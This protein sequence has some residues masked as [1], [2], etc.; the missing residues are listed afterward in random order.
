MGLNAVSES[1]AT[2]GESSSKNK[3]GLTRNK[4]GIPKLLFLI[5]GALVEELFV[6]PDN[7]HALV[8]MFDDKR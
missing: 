1:D 2:S 7:A 6:H 4:R 8:A 5:I 3:T